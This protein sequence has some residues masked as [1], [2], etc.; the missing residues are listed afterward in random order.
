MRYGPAGMCLLLGVLC[1]SPADAQVGQ[2]SPQGKAA[3]VALAEHG[4]NLYEKHRYAEALEAFRNADSTVHAPPFLLM[5]ARCHV[6]LGRLLD[7][8]NA[9]QRIVDEQFGAG[10]PPAFVEAQGTAKKELAEIEPRIPT[11]EIV[12]TGTAAGALVLTLD[13][14][15]VALSTPVPGDP[16]DH[17]LMVHAPGRRPLTRTIRL[18]EG[19]RE[20]VE[21]DQATMDALPVI[22]RPDS[23]RGPAAKMNMRPDTL[24]SPVPET[25]LGTM[26]TAVLL[27]GGIAAGAGV[28]AGVILTVMANSRASEAEDKRNALIDQGYKDSSCRGLS[29][30]GCK[31][32][33]DTVYAKVDLS[34]AAFWS[35]VAGGAIGVGTLVYG[36]V[37]S[38]PVEKAAPSIGLAPLIGP[39]VT[40]VS[41]SGQL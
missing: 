40:G 8:R 26:R 14:Q 4:W 23:E 13:G 38:K 35:F 20:R 9:Y 2:T 24:I 5:V 21:L 41:L 17:T 1:A 29:M 19:V 33:R 7:A 6:K 28:A 27:G 3:A 22:E 15:S 12:V 25:R 18:V 32:L 30:P 10:A 31:D 36:L 11:V 16:G 37:T 34:N 39:R